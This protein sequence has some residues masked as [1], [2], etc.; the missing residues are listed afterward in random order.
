MADQKKELGTDYKALTVVYHSGYEVE[1][2]EITVRDN[3]VH[4]VKSLFRPNVEA[5]TLNRLHME[6]RRLFCPGGRDI[7][8]PH[9]EKVIWRKDAESDSRRSVRRSSPVGS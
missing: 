9:A 8:P 5:I 7:P 2:L 3:E 6:S 1:L 4:E